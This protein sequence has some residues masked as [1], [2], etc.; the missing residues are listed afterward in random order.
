MGGQCAMFPQTTE[1]SMGLQWESGQWIDV[2]TLYLCSS[3]CLLHSRGLDL[4]LKDLL[5]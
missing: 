2:V 4:L 3:G 5:K 1:L